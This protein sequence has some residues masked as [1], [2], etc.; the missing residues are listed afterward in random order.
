MSLPTVAPSAAA[1]GGGGGDAAGAGT[2]A[3]VAQRLNDLLGGGG[4]DGNDGGDPNDLI[5]RDT[6]LLGRWR[7]FVKELKT[8]YKSHVDCTPLAGRGGWRG[9]FFFFFFFFAGMMG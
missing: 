2:G 6:S 9:V 5:G 3:A 8:Y 7:T 1:P 4:G